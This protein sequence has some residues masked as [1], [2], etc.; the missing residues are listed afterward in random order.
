[1]INTRDGHLLY[2]RE[3]CSRFSSDCGVH[4]LCKLLNDDIHPPRSVCSKHLV[5]SL[6]LLCHSVSF[7][8]IVVDDLSG[9]AALDRRY[10]LYNCYTSHDDVSCAVIFQVHSTQVW[11]T[12]SRRSS[13]HNSSATQNN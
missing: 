10:D 12:I 2:P 1:M 9:Y 3:L 13:S 7:D 5:G 11:R 4:G 8:F 6:S